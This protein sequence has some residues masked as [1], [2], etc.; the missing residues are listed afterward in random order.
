MAARDGN[1]RL[2]AAGARLSVSPDGAG[3]TWK[4]VDL[5]MVSPTRTKRMRVDADG[6]LWVSLYDRGVVTLD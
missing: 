1:G 6:T 3:R 4:L 2:W 5:P